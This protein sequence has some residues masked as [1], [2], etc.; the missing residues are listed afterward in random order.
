MQYQRIKPVLG[1]ALLALA[2]Q[3]QAASYL[4]F[5]GAGNSVTNYSEAGLLAFDLDFSH[6]GSIRLDFAIE[7]QDL[8]QP[9][10]SFNALVRNLSGIGFEGVS[11]S[12]EGIGFALPKGTLTTDGFQ[13]VQSWGSNSQ[14]LWARFEPQLTSEFY[15]GNPLAEAGAA[16]WT[17]DLNGRQAGEHFSITVSV[18]EPESYALMLAGLAAVGWAARRRRG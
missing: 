14:A 9:L 5:S 3:A 12:L 18:P 1:A 17:L 11:L 7:A 15:I 6:K 8:V 16:D 4:G 10:L 2:V 13:A